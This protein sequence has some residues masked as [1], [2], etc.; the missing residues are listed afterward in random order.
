MF[1]E[2]S[3][4]SMVCGRAR[5]NVK[6]IESATRTAIY[7]PPPFPQVYGYSPPGGTRREPDQIFITGSSR[8]DIAKAERMLLNLVS[9][10]YSLQDW[11]IDLETNHLFRL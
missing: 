2:L 8:E 4:Q 5:K 3:V 6:L 7:F 1:M 10:A 11:R 9:P